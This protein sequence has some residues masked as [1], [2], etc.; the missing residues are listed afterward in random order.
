[1]RQSAGVSG[2]GRDLR[3]YVEGVRSRPGSRLQFAAVLAFGTGVVVRRGWAVA[4]AILGG[5]LLLGLA[6]GYWRFRRT[7][8]IY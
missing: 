1:M 2:G 6:I 3:T 5:A 4:A 7:G 8:R